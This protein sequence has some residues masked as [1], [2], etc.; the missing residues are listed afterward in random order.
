M[1]VSKKR[2]RGGEEG[3]GGAG[4]DMRFISVDDVVFKRTEGSRSE[5]DYFGSKPYVL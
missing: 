4:G 2:G 1:R 3:E 5:T